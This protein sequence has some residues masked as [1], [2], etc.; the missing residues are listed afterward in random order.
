MSVQELD[1]LVWDM[2][3]KRVMIVSKDGHDAVK[4]FWKRQR[5]SW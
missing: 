5:Q 2:P 1:V 4:R 3:E